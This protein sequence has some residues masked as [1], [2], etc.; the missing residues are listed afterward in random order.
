[1]TVYVEGVMRERKIAAARGG[2][3]VLIEGRNS[4]STPRGSDSEKKPANLLVQD[5]A[6]IGQSE[7]PTEDREK[8]RRESKRLKEKKKKKTQ[9]A[10]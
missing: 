1:L 4:T 2:E 6:I 10:H 3:K 9:Y 7:V 8:E 5:K